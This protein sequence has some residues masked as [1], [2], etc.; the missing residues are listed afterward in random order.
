MESQSIAHYAAVP[1]VREYQNAL[2]FYLQK[3]HGTGSVRFWT[4]ATFW[5]V[6]DVVKAGNCQ[7]ASNLI[8]YDYVAFKELHR[9]CRT[10]RV[11]RGPFDNIF[12]IA[13]KQS[14]DGRSLARRI[15]FA[16]H[17]ASLSLRYALFKVRNQSKQLRLREAVNH[18]YEDSPGD[19]ERKLMRILPKCLVEDFEFYA[20]INAINSTPQDTRNVKNGYA[21]AY[22]MRIDRG[23]ETKLRQ[24]GAFYGEVKDH[25]GTEIESQLCSYY[26]TWG[27]KYCNHHVPGSAHTLERIDQKYKKCK[28][29][30]R[31]ILI[32]MPSLIETADEHVLAEFVGLIQKTSALSQHRFV[33][34]GRPSDKSASE[35]LERKLESI[36]GGGISV[37]CA[38]DV[39]DA[40]AAAKLVICL[41]HPAT[42]FLQC[43][44]SDIPVMGLAR[45]VGEY[46]DKYKEHV[47]E[48]LSLGMLHH[49]VESLVEFMQP[50]TEKIQ[51]WWKVVRETRGFLCYQAKYCA[52]GSERSART[53]NGMS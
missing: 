40:L 23:K 19:R 16:W 8:P 10:E 5:Y 31:V 49:S 24:H 36:V 34:R 37:H 48:L 3:I 25:I 32:A 13:I 2:I 6:V 7:E 14:G 51:S 30:N 38:G 35:G 17:Y 43:V 26:Y 21:I 20:S 4:L 42:L 11:C 1:R 33:V 41:N 53:K 39:S 12:D 27:W 9:G 47:K 52:G 50:S 29:R 22:A 15:K 18:I 44:Y 46:H 45:P 28:N